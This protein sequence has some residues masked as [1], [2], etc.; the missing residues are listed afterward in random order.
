MWCVYLFTRTMNEINQL[1]KQLEREQN[2]AITWTI[3]ANNL[4]SFVMYYKHKK[5]SCYQN[6]CLCITT[7]VNLLSNNNKIYPEYLCVCVRKR[8][9]VQFVYYLINVCTLQNRKS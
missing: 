3:E 9:S 7:I 6:T 5:K 8:V 2:I 1:A 4:C